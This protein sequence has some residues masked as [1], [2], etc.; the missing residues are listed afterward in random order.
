MNRASQLSLIKGS[1]SIKSILDYEDHEL[2]E[3]GLIDKDTYLDY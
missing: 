3:R 2:D 1:S